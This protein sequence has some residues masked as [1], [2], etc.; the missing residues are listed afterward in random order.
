MYDFLLDVLEEPSTAS[1]YFPK[2]VADVLVELVKS[3]I[4]KPK[5]VVKAIATIKSYSPNGLEEVKEILKKV[6]AKYKANIHYLGAP[7]YMIIVEDEDYKKANKRMK[8]I[9]EF[10]LSSSNESSFEWEE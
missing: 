8:K 3:S 7:R 4:K 2:K 9:E 1:L 6:K 10:I 5:A